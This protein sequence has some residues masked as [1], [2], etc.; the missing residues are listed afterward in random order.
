MF[1]ISVMTRKSEHNAAASRVADGIEGMDAGA[2]KY[3]VLFRD[4]DRRVALIT[5]K[6]EG[7]VN[8]TSR[9]Q[10]RLISTEQGREL[11]HL[12]AGAKE[13]DL[14][15]SSG[16]SP[17]KQEEAWVCLKKGVPGKMLEA[18]LDAVRGCGRER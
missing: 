2:E 17:G 16:Y 4:G 15:L 3:I 18:E 7:R 9:V 8:C 5:R 14:L 13:T 11:E 10:L 12:M 1:V 6:G